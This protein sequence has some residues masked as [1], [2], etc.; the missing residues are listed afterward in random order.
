[1]RKVKKTISLSACH[2][3]GDKGTKGTGEWIKISKK[4]KKNIKDKLM[5]KACVPTRGAIGGK[6]QAA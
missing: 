5:G 2:R 4:K 6:S 3:K 1:M